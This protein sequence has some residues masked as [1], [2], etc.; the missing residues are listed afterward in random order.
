MFRCLE[1]GVE[2]FKIVAVDGM[3]VIP[4]GSKAFP[5]VFALRHLGHRIEGDVVRIVNQDQIVQF[6]MPAKRGGFGGNTFLQATVSGQT[7]DLVIK[8]GVLFG[9]ESGLGHLRRNGHS[10][11]VSY[12]LSQRTGG[13]LYA[14]GIAKFRVARSFAMELPEVFDVL[15][16]NVVSGKM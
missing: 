12:A 9:V 16:R 15:E 5:G 13:R 8:Y 4:I 2:R 1:R 7:D 6:L 11:G 10:D 14:R 3:H